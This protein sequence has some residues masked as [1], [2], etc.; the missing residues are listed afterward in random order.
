MKDVC[1]KAIFPVRRKAIFALQIDRYAMRYLPLL[2]LTLL[3]AAGCAD[4]SSPAGSAKPVTG[5][6]NQNA[7][8]RQDPS[9]Q[10]RDTPGLV[11][12]MGEATVKKGEIAC[13]PVEVSGFKDM[14]AFQYTLR[15]DS[16]ALQFH[17]VRG[18]T[19]A[20]YQAS[21][22]G[23]RFADRGY[24]STLWTAKD[25]VAG[26]SLPDQHKLYEVCFEN[27]QPAK[28]ETEVKFQNG[29]TAFEVIGPNM[30]RHRLVYANGKVVSR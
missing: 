28:Q 16:T 13:L 20:G 29:P 27:L 23:T 21:N 26:T 8:L 18:L 10:D 1:P 14:L 15:F 19:L 5:K 25:V 3:F 30:A 17:S 11:F 2:F 4:T 22:F 6:V 24:L 7:P 9:D 12:R